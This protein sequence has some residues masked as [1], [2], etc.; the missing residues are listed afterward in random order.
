MGSFYGYA[1]SLAQIDS[2]GLG[3]INDLLKDLGGW[4]IL[5][6]S[7]SKVRTES[8]VRDLLIKLN[9]MDQNVLMEQWV[10]ADDKDSSVNIIQVCVCVWL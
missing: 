10:S 1:V 3:P 4:P 8:D 2:E 7:S 9:L 6:G 5:E